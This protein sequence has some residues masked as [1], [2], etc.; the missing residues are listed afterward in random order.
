MG[1]VKTRIL[2]VDIFLPPG[3]GLPAI[4][5]KM[6]NTGGGAEV[7]ET[8]LLPRTFSAF[9]PVQVLTLNRRSIQ[10][11]STGQTLRAF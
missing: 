2:G 4:S 11:Q 6:H 7:P 8:Q 3:A 9:R 10:G 1:K 5:L